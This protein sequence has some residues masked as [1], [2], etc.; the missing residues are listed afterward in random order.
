LPHKKH[1]NQL[2]TT[3]PQTSIER[4]LWQFDYG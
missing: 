3:H 4:F 2:T 1:P